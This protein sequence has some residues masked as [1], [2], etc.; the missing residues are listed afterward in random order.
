MAAIVRCGRF[1]FLTPALAAAFLKNEPHSGF[2]A[3]I[4]LGFRQEHAGKEQRAEGIGRTGVIWKENR[5]LLISAVFQAVVSISHSMGAAKI[6]TLHCLCLGQ[7][8]L[9]QL[10]CFPILQKI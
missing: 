2:V 5:E 9:Q 3:L 10:L 8:M 1:S 7:V 6:N 4:Y